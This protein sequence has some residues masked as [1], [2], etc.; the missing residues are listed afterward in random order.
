MDLSSTAF[1]MT[2]FSELKKKQLSFI[3]P[4]SLSLTMSDS[5]TSKQEHKN[6]SGI[7]LPV[8]HED[9]T[10]VQDVLHTT[11]G[12]Y[13]HIT[14]AYT[15]RHVAKK[16]LKW[17]GSM[18]ADRLSEEPIE[19]V[20][21]KINSFHWDKTG[22]TRHDVLMM[23]SKK[24]AARI[25]ENQTQ[26]PNQGQLYWLDMELNTKIKIRFLRVHF[27]LFFFCLHISRHHNS[28]I[29]CDGPY[30]GLGLVFA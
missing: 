11:I 23:L 12:G 2:L 18:F 19:L 26:I 22:K 5:K 3:F 10:I 21:A 16:E 30:C 14:V 7:F 1:Y 28:H 8:W 6:V 9:Y 17:L 24:D 20:G 13:P 15:G 25:E 27:S 29:P 4:L